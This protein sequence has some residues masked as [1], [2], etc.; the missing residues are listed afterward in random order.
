[1]IE[2]T[3]NNIWYK[4][5]HRNKSKL[6]RCFRVFLIILLI[7]AIIF[8]YFNFTCKNI[9]DICTNVAKSFC[10]ESANNAVLVSLDESDLYENIINIEKNSAGDITLIST[11]S[12]KINSISKKVTQNTLLFLR[13]NLNKGIK[14]PILAFLGLN[15]LSGY[16]SE[17]ELKLVNIASVNCEFS[18]EFKSVGINQTLHSIFININC[19]TNIHMPLY[20]ESSILTSSIL[21]SEAVLVGKVPDTY[22]NGSIF[23]W[24]QLFK[25]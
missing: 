9:V 11:D 17:V 4:N 2:C 13:E 5:K 15:I 23:K 6:K 8:Y 20:K 22:L 14:I 21:I 25:R 16:G 10:L 24:F 19:E 7:V 3:N 1:M 12:L 18:S